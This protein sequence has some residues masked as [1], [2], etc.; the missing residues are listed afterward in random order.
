VVSCAGGYEFLLDLQLNGILVA[1]FSFLEASSI[2]MKLSAVGGFGV[3][4]ISRVYLA[5]RNFLLKL[6]FAWQSDL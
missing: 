2:Q 3:C 1:C 5:S 6:I 4:C